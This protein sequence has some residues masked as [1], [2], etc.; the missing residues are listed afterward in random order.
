MSRTIADKVPLR[1]RRPATPASLTHLAEPAC[2]Q[3]WVTRAREIIDSGFDGILADNAMWSL[4]SRKPL[5]VAAPDGIMDA[6]WRPIG[7][8]TWQEMSGVAGKRG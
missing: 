2:Q 3:A 1:R 8:V 5:S 6:N 7:T 4:N